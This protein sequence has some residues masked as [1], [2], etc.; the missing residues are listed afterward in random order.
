M[1]FGC[2]L[3]VPLRICFAVL[4]ALLHFVLEKGEN[5]VVPVNICTMLLIIRQPKRG[6]GAEKNQNQLRGPV[7]DA[8]RKRFG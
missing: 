2:F 7:T 4:K 6:I 8:M 1:K 5:L 3:V